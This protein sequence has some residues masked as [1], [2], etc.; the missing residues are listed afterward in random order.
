MLAFKW[1]RFTPNTAAA[2]LAVHSFAVEELLSKNPYSNV[3]NT[4]LA[5][6]KIL[7]KIGG[8]SLLMNPLESETLSQFF[9]NEILVSLGPYTDLGGILKFKVETPSHFGLANSVIEVEME[10]EPLE[11]LKAQV[12]HK[13]NSSCVWAFQPN[14]FYPFRRKYS[15]IPWFFIPGATRKFDWWRSPPAIQPI[16]LSNRFEAL[17]EV[18]AAPMDTDASDDIANAQEWSTAQVKDL[19]QLKLQQLYMAGKGSK[20]KFATG[21]YG[22]GLTIPLQNMSIKDAQG[23]SLEKSALYKLAEAHG[24]VG[25]FA[26]FL[27]VC[28]TTTLRPLLDNALHFASLTHCVN[29]AVT[30]RQSTQVGQ[31]GNQFSFLFSSRAVG[32]WIHM[33]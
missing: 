15:G 13:A 10:R 25:D 3:V 32:K 11:R 14:H 20:D 31:R 7:E 24:S 28:T 4:R 16:P 5:K 1:L 21:S 22:S 9:S 6:D 18:D 26:K 33:I 23:K 29:V 30:S 17:G 19:V 27:G 2:Q 12:N 8:R